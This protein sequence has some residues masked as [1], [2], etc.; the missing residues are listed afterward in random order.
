METYEEIQE[1]LQEGGIILYFPNFNIYGIQESSTTF[2]RGEPSLSEVSVQE[3]NFYVSTQDCVDNQVREGIEL[4]VKDSTYTF[5]LNILNN[6]IPFIDGWSRL[7]VEM[8]R[9]ELL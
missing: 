1:T 8:I 9:K 4:Q 6:P 2:L 3:Y 5:T 7:P